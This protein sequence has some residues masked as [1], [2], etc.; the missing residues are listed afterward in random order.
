MYALSIVRAIDSRE[1][2]PVAQPSIDAIEVLEVRVPRRAR[3][4]IST[5]YAV[6]PDAH[7]A[8]VLVHSGEL[9]GIGEAP[10]ELWWTGEDATSVRNAIERYLAPALVG[11]PHGIRSA[12]AAMDA[13]L[14]ANPYAKAAIEMALWDLLGKRAQMPLYTLLGGG[15]PLPVP[16]KYVLGML[17]RDQAREEARRGLE[18]G[19]TWLKVKVG[20]ELDSDL[21]RVAAVR[22]ELPEDGHL[23]VDANGGWSRI[24]ALRAIDRLAA[25]DVQFIEQPVSRKYPQALADVTSRSPIPIVAHESLV[26]VEDGL[27]A[28]QCDLAHVWALTPST[29]GGLTPT[30]DLL[31]IAGAAGI[32]CLLGSTVELGVATAFLAHIGAAFS[33]IATSPIP[34]DVIGPLYHE[35]DIVVGGASLVGGFATVGDAPGLGVELDRERIERFAVGAVR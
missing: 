13:A 26:T 27:D 28:V 8:L 6:L 22:K 2:S 30:V 4:R 1:L 32:P 3:N 15:A 9:V 7:H 34:S 35:D 23:G 5:S 16:I 14:A 20:G 24:D 31:G 10:A 21:E 17:N 33:T 11:S 25:L 18:L 19:F 12:V 29:H